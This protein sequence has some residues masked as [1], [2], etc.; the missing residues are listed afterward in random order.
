MTVDTGNRIETGLGDA[1][2]RTLALLA[3]IG[4]ADL[5]RQ[6]SPLMSPLVWD[7]AHVG[8]Y[9]ELWL[10]RNT[11]GA[12]PTNALMLRNILHDAGVPVTDA[13]RSALA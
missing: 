5:V 1:R 2:A 9:E 10:L 4:D 7:L 12:A 6:V 3:P 8:H 11:V 13:R